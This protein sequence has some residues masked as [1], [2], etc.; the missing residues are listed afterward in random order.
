MIAHRYQ[1]QMTFAIK[2]N[3]FKII[4]AINKGDL[5]DNEME[6]IMETITDSLFSICVTLGKLHLFLQIL[7]PLYSSYYS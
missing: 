3:F 5:T 7:T 1:Y 2:S 6:S 4:L